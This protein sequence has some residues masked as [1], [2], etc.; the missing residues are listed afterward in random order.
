MIGLA[1]EV[2]RVVNEGLAPLAAARKKRRLEE[3]PYAGQDFMVVEVG[4]VALPRM[5]WEQLN[6]LGVFAALK[7][8]ARTY[9][10]LRAMRLV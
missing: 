2:V 10:K 6:S 3:S 8:A 7:H 5:T 1:S 4:T 9:E